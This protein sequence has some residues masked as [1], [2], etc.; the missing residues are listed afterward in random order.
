MD[1][2]GFGERPLP[3]RRQG[4]EQ[5]NQISKAH[6]FS[7]NRESGFFACPLAPLRQGACGQA[8]TVCHRHR[9]GD[10]SMKRSLWA[11]AFSG[12]LATTWFTHPIFLDQIWRLFTDAGCGMDPDG[13]CAGSQIDEGCGMDPDG[14]CRPAPQ[15]DEGCGMDPN[16]CPKG[17]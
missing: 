5:P 16:G 2:C 9:A 10:E 3:Q 4:T 11:L 14:K 7:C 1:S 12:F 17:S 15:V 6:E 13:V 8:T